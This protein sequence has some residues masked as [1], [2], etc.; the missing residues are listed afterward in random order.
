M[1]NALKRVAKL[2]SYIICSFFAT[3]NSYIN[4]TIHTLQQTAAADE[5]VHV[6]N[7]EIATL[8]ENKTDTLKRKVPAL[9]HPEGKQG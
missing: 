9:P 7:E 3:Q 8:K 1:L 5:N 2:L 6:N 4:N